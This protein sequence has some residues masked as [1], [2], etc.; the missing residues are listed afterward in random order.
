MPRGMTDLLEV[1]VLP[2]SAHDFLHGCRAAVRL[3]ALFLPRNTFLNC[4]IP[5][6]VN[7]NVGSSPGTTG[8]AR[9]HCMPLLFKVIGEFLSDFGLPS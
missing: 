3:P 9:V 4:T 2:A 7:I 6:L 5:A 8:S 1:V